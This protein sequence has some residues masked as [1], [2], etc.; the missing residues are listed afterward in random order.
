M[1]Q[2]SDPIVK[3]IAMENRWHEAILTIL[4]DKEFMK[5][6]LASQRQEAAGVQGEPWS[7]V[8]VRLGLE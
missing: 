3:A 7:L 5:G 4:N 6:V 8:K 1:S 2:E